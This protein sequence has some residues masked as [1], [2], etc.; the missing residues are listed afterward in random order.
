[1]PRSGPASVVVMVLLLIPALPVGMGAVAPAL[2]GIHLPH[3]G[4]HPLAASG[5]FV[6]VSNFEDR[7]LDGWSPTSGTATVSTTTNYLG[8]PSLKST[9]RGSVPQIDHTTR[10]FVAGDASLSF[11]A[12][13]NYAASGAG[14]VGLADRTGP[15]AVV[16]IS[17][18]SVAAGATPATATAIGPIPTSGTAQPAGWVDLLVYLNATT[19]STPNTAPWLMTVYVDRTDVAAATNLRLPG[20]GNYT[21]AILDT[22]AGTVY[23]TDLT[24][25]TYQIPTT[26]PGYN[27]MDGYGQGSGLIVSLL[28]GFT[29]LSADMTLSNW[30][31]PQAGIIGTQINAM[32]YRGTT[33]STC[34]GFFQLGVDLNPGGR[35]APWYVPGVNCVATY[36]ATNS[37]RSNGGFVTPPGSHLT[38]SITI[39]PTARTIE[40]QI[41]DLSVAL[42]H[43]YW[44][45]SIPY[46]G[47]KFFGVYTQIEWQPCCS[48]HPI[49]SYFFNGTVTHLRISG[50]NL[51]SVQPLS[52]SYMIP[53]AL[54]VPPSWNFGF[55][56]A[57]MAGYAQ[58]G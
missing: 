4:I 38:L 6:S 11:Q 39:D 25:T 16:G 12:V 24:F 15:V 19:P 43:R 21:G 30:N 1:M 35:I 47:T 13:V 46:Y 54:D 37:T 23:Y 3:T 5:P 55:Y 26:I 7:H 48:T 22:T 33:L 14:F 8:E 17:A 56:D 31:V 52:A 51:T 2:S 36:F 53:F 27:N 41:V 45:A 49:G 34:T 58:V 44:N 9:V 18:G 28:P 29:T 10:S 20:A 42:S 40:F 50:G 32:D 57:P